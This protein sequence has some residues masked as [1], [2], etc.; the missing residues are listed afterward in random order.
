MES[1]QQFGNR[2]NTRHLILVLVIWW[3]AMLIAYSIITLRVN[4]LKSELRK[5]GVEYTHEFSNLVSLP[6]LE[7][8]SQSISTLLTDAVNRTDVIYASVVDHRNKVI[9]FTGTGHLMPDRTEAVRSVEKVAMWE[10]GFSSHAKILNFVS[11]VIY[12]G[13]KIGEIFIG[14]STPETFQTRKQFLFIAVLSSLILLF[15]IAVLRY[16]TIKPFLLKYLNLN[17]SSTAIDPALQKKSILCPLC[18]TQQPVSGRLF[19]R[20]A[21]DKFLRSGH[22]EHIS[23]PV[24]V[25]DAN[26]TDLPELAGKEDLSKMRRQIILR[27]IEIIKK[28]TA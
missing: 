7:R 17:R 11:D 15:L 6:L 9:A 23:N 2:L 8:N 4:R 18:G 13:T 21:L 24:S 1:I 27:C 25:A 26:K 14:L 22:S 16:P 5:T 28:L 20:S 3:L 19:K 12:A 10:G